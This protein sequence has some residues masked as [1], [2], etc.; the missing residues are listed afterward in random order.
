MRV[1]PSINGI[2]AIVRGPR[3]GSSLLPCEDTEK[4]APSINQEASPHQ[5]CR[6]QPNC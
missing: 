4:K 2:S 6:G 3:D 1:E 5:I